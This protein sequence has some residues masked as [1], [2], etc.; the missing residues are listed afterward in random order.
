MAKGKLT[1]IPVDHAEPGMMLGAAVMSASGQTILTAG[2]LLDETHIDFLK[3][4]GIRTVQVSLTE[5]EMSDPEAYRKILERIGTGPATPPSVIDEVDVTRIDPAGPT[6]VLDRM[7]SETPPKDAPTEKDVG[8]EER[9]KVQHEWKAK[10]ETRKKK[11]E[12]KHGET[13]KTVGRALG[14][15]RP[16]GPEENFQPAKVFSEAVRDVTEHLYLEKQLND[17]TLDLLTKNITMEILSRQGMATLLSR[18]QA[19]GQYLLAHMVNVSVYSMYVAIQMELSS[20]E[21]KDTSIGGLLSDIGMLAMP[22]PFWTL[23]RKLSKKEKDELIRHPAESRRM[24]ME[25]PG[26]REEWARIAYQHHERLDGSGYPLGLKVP[27]INLY[28][29]IV[30]VCDVYSASTADRAYRDAHFPDD[31]MRMMMGKP[32]LYDRSIVE[33]FCQLVGFFPEGY[34]VLLSSGEHAVVIST[35]PKN[36][37]RPIV[38]FRKD[39]N[40]RPLM[41]AEQV[42]VDLSSRLDLRIIKVLEDDSVRWI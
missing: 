12:K 35:N 13:Y 34:V 1:P 36:I 39:K 15:P 40:G 42:V 31:A 16:L 4:R 37:F 33:I 10:R 24:I 19:A 38:R 3:R 41:P 9:D 11:M 14:E 26:T 18:A 20:Q 25:A 7:P 22:E 27:D 32:D 5:F 28:S 8:T 6:V 30:Q 2:V 29:R 23:E 21:I 17:D